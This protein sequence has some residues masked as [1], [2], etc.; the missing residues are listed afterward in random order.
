MIGPALILL[1]ASVVPFV[2]H[3]MAAPII[4][5]R[6]VERSTMA[7]FEHLTAELGPWVSVSLEGHSYVLELGGQRC[8]V[9]VLSDTSLAKAAHDRIVYGF[10]PANA[11]RRYINDAT[12]ARPARV[13]IIMPTAR[14]A[15]LPIALSLVQTTYIERGDTDD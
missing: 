3:V 7:T 8:L 11:V 6:L 15:D 13:A 2:A 12:R 5:R 14:S 1:A 9:G 10:G 4:A